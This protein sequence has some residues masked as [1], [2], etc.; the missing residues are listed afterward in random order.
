MCC[1]MVEAGLR[2]ARAHGITRRT[3]GAPLQAHQGWRW[4]LAEAALRSSR[5]GRK[6]VL[7]E[8]PLG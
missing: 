5:E 1:A 2:L 8:S 6:V 7:D 4:Q 3:F